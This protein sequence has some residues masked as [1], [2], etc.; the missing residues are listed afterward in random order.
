M[1]IQLAQIIFQAINFG[2]VLFVLTRFIYKPVLK[3]L[4]DR[5]KKVAQAAKSSNEILQEKENL[6]KMK[7]DILSKANQN[8]QK[9]ENDT[10][11]EAKKSAKILMEKSKEELSLKETKFTEE[12][13]K[14]KKDK[15]KS[16]EKE[17]KQAAVVIAEK[18]LQ[19]SIDAKKHQKLIDQQIDE[20]IESL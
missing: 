3:L 10:K 2:L 19:E 17:L 16:M 12:L 15:L 20:I 9:I 5:K 4:E 14:L 6:E 13:A 1:D 8:A 18:V 7:A 11:N